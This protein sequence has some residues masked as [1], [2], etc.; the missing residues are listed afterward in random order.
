MKDLLM[1]ATVL[2][3]WF[4]LSR[5][6]L[7]ALG[8]PTCM[9][10]QCGTCP[11]SITQPADEPPPSAGLSPEKRAEKLGISP[12][13]VDPLESVPADAGGKPEDRGDH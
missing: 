4:A 3:A 5:W 11:T 1:M 8:I 7:P 10:G 12:L 9:S 13:D 2:I 6:V